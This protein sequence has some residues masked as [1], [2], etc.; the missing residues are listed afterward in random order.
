MEPKFLADSML[1][2]L[3]RWLILLGYDARYAHG[4]G[5][6]DLELLE[7]AH[8]EGR[9]FLTRDTK[10]PAVAGLRMIV[11][12]G[13]RF[14]DQLKQVQLEMGLKPDRKK[15]FT[16]CTY[17]N[18]ALEE[19]SK[20]QALPLVPPLVRELTTPFFRCP[21]CKRMYWSGTH[22]ERTVKRLEKLGL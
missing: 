16:R 2:K 3:A 20:E 18:L 8:R 10:I 5:V 15:L 17:C 9:V 4:A 13:Q 7:A 1:G 11:V 19:L 21:S 22:T 12:R 6:A 14:E